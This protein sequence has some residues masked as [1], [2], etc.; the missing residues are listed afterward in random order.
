[1]STLITSATTNCI[2]NFLFRINI[3]VVI[4]LS[5][6]ALAFIMAF[7][8]AI[9]SSASHLPRRSSGRILA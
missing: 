4:T 2:L 9:V 7:S 8:L 1:M 3:W 5:F 6:G